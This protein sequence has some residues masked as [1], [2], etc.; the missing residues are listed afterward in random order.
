MRDIQTRNDLGKYRKY[1]YY[2]L[3]LFTLLQKN[4]SNS[5]HGMI[6]YRIM[7]EIPLD[8]P[9]KLRRYHFFNASIVIR[10]V[11]IISAEL[12]ESGIFLI[13]NIID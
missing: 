11:Y 13:N 4:R 8:G 2:L 5:V 6:K 10:A 3:I 12:I 7:L 1:P 9:A